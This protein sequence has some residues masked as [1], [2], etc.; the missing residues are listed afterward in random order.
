MIHRKSLFLFSFF[1]P[2][3]HFLSVVH[4]LVP[5]LGT[6]KVLRS[7]TRLFGSLDRARSESKVNIYQNDCLNKLRNAENK[8]RKGGG[9]FHRNHPQ[10]LRKHLESQKDH[11][12][13][14][15][16]SE[17]LDQNVVLGRLD[18]EGGVLANKMKD[19]KA[20]KEEQEDEG[21]KEGDEKNVDVG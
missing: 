1:I 9:A 20:K 17:L 19:S 5:V 16:D 2:Y 15:D 4:I 18:V 14:S 13:K 12:A 6:K 3:L 21:E 11:G 7:R 8:G 10:T